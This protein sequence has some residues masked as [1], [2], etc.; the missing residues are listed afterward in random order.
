MARTRQTWA[1]KASAS[2]KGCGASIPADEDR[3]NGRA[4]LIL[5]V[6]LLMEDS[7]LEGTRVLSRLSRQL[8]LCADI[9]ELAAPA[10]GCDSRQIDPGLLRVVAGLLSGQPGP[11]LV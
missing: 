11:K 1:G 9:P 2:R 3:P 5:L 6:S 10:L 4:E 7:D 8:R